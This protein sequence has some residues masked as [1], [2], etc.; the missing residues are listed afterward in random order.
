MIR[1]AACIDANL[2][3][4]GIG[5]FPAFH[6]CINIRILLLECGTWYHHPRRQQCVLGRNLI[7]FK[8]AAWHYRCRHHLNNNCIWHDLL[9][10]LLFCSQIK[11]SDLTTIHRQ[12][13]HQAVLETESETESWLLQQ[14]NYDYFLHFNCRFILIIPRLTEWRPFKCQGHTVSLWR[15]PLTCDLEKCYLLRSSLGMYNLERRLRYSHV[16]TSNCPQT[17]FPEQA[18]PKHEY[19][20]QLSGH[21]VTSSPWKILFWHNLGRS[22]HSWGQ[23]EAVF[24]ISKFS[25]WPAFWGRDKL[26]FT[27]SNTGSCIY[28]QDSH[29]HFRYFELLIDA[30]AEILIG[31]I[32]I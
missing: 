18:S 24:N 28:E 16:L 4:V 26:F 1:Y 17:L 9:C 25:K 12:M 7:I 20:Q 2:I 11:T 8:V 3:S 14:H 10:C 22:S 27:G 32:A 15:W 5:F 21:P 23:I 31:D 29:E 19:R 30:V 13:R 6:E